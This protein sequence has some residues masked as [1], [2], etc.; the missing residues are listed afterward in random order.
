MAV[1]IGMVLAILI[2]RKGGISPAQMLIKEPDARKD[3]SDKRPLTLEDLYKFGKHLCQENELTIKE[4]F[5]NSET[6]V[7]WVVES[8]NPIFYGNYVFGFYQISSSQL[9]SM[10][11]VLKFKDFIKSAGNGKGFLFTT[12]YFST[13]VHQPLEGP[14]VTLYNRHKIWEE[15]SKLGIS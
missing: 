2:T 12:G 8:K 14:A 15:L 1:F 10:S 6:E 5:P 11:D 4:E 13:D 3:P 9:I 7:Y